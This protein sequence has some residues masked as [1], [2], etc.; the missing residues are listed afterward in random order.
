MEE[1]VAQATRMVEQ[2]TDLD[3]DRDLLDGR[4]VVPHG[5]IE[6]DD[7]VLREREDERG[8]EGLAD[9]GDRE[10]CLASHG[11]P[12]SDVGHAADAGPGG[13]IGQD[14]GDGDARDAVT[15]PETVESSLQRETC[16]R[17]E[18]RARDRHGRSD[19]RRVAGLRPWAWRD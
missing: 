6:I 16:L 7:P 10:R 5:C 14:D 12:G 15:L 18:T 2:L 1:E 9:A 8:G 4:E 19:D 13:A 11:R 3:L 17:R